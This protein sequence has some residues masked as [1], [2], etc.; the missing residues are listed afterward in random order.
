MNKTQI[1]KMQRTFYNW[2]CKGNVFD[3]EWSLMFVRL[4][5]QEGGSGRLQEIIKNAKDEYKHAC[6]I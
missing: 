4:Y 3:K 2:Q 1:K 6:I 5:E